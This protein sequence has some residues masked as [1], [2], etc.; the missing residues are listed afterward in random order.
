M[1][2]LQSAV[3]VIVNGGSFNKHAVAIFVESKPFPVSTIRI[4]QHVIHMTIVKTKYFI[5]AFDAASNANSSSNSSVDKKKQQIT[6]GNIRNEKVLEKSFISVRA[7]IRSIRVLVY[8]RKRV[9]R[10][11]DWMRNRMMNEINIIPA[12]EDI[13]FTSE[14]S[15]TEKSMCIKQIASLSH[16]EWFCVLFLISISDEL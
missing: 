2:Q 10:W 3:I 5:F 11:G 15:Y 7:F 9:C 16:C 6:H 1:T 14:R 4:R 8:I 12:T 13:P